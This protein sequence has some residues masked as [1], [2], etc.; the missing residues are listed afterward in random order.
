MLFNSYIFVFLFL[1][2]TLLFWYG[3]NR[4]GLPRAAQAALA[5]LSLVF[6]GYEKPAYVLL[7]LGSVLGNWCISGA[8]ARVD[9]GAE[10]GLPGH[11]TGTPG[12]RAGLPGHRA[13]TPGHRAGTLLGVLGIALNLGLLFYFKYYDF[14]L[15]N[16]NRVTGAEFAL[17]HIALPLGISFFTFQQISFM[18]DRMRRMAPHYAL[19]DY[20][21]FVTFFPQLVAGPIVNHG[22]L[23][24]Q[25]AEIGKRGSAQGRKLF[26]SQQ[27]QKGLCLFA[28]GLAKKVLLADKLGVFVDYG[29]GHV[30]GLDAVAAFAVMLAYTFQIYFDFS[31]YSDM[32]VGLG[33]MFGIRLPRNFDSPYRAH[34]VGE[35][36]NRWHMTLN[37]FFTRYV[38]IPLGGSRHG[39]IKKLRNIMIVFLLSGIWHGAAWSFVLWG[40]AHGLMLCLENLPAVERIPDRLRWFVTFLFVNLAWV[41][42]RSGSLDG[43][44]QFYRRLFSFTYGGSIWELAKQVQASW[45]YPLQRITERLFGA[46]ALPV[47]FLVLFVLLLVAAAALCCG[48]NAYDMIAER[49]PK[50]RLVWGLAALF[51][52]SVFSF[53]GVTAFLYFNF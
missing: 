34:S 4:L 32:A 10:S 11:R 20:L 44:L 7:I 31:G 39:M 16:I 17:K 50:D 23:A 33:W 3:L 37:A 22:D 26:D 49:E 36:W 48:R 8:I 2:I 24:P 40:A 12:H 29:Y 45:N 51:A 15:K 47:L 25:F 53:S 13:G 30:A 21:N 5:V 38:Y 28:A 35:F 14:F 52:L 43:A 46:A 19:P 6:Y 27:M 9:A 42:F 1:P 18:A 41:L